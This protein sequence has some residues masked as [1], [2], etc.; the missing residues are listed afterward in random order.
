MRTSTKILLAVPALMLLFG[1]GV[2]LAE[3]VSDIYRQLRGAVPSAVA[4]QDAET[5]AQSL[6]Y[7][8]TPLNIRATNGNPRV[9]ANASFSVDGAQTCALECMLY[10]YDGSTYTPLGIAG[11]TTLTGAVGRTDGTRFFAQG[12]ATFDTHAATHYDLRLRG[13][14]ASGN[15]KVIHWPYGG[16][17]RNEEAP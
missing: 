4:T 3:P 8:G 16:A 1:A 14:P 11:I 6:T 5:S 12:P 13:V 7:N 2:V 17:K 15:V 9:I 10:Y